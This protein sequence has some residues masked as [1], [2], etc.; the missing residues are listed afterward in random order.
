MTVK[1]LIEELK[2]LDENALVSAWDGERYTTK[3]EVVAREDE[4]MWVGDEL[5]KVTYLYL[6][7]P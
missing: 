3:F 7:R 6:G 5:K 1:E 2:K 4:K